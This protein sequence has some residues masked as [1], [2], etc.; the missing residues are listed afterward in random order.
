MEGK[1]EYQVIFS[2]HDAKW[3]NLPVEELIIALRE[4]VTPSTP[5]TVKKVVDNIATNEVQYI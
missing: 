5:I 4:L 2:F 1:A 3:G